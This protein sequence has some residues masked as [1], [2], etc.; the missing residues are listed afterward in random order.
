MARVLI[1]GI[2]P[3]EVDFSDP[4]LP[5]GLT[6]ALIRQG[7]V[8][9]QEALDRAG[10]AVE[11][12][13]V[14]ADP[15]R[16]QA[17]AQRLEADRFDCVIVGGGICLP[18][19]NRTLFEAALNVIARSRHHPAIALVSRPEEVADAAARVLPPG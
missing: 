1:I 19:R 8:R 7:I 5:P 17:F 18:P 9:G 15:S 12:M 4:A 16:L 14:P 13:F 11:H 2:D 3:D 6:A 10:H